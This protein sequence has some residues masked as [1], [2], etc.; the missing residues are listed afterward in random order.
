[1]TPDERHGEAQLQTQSPDLE[2]EQLAK[3]LDQ[4][5]AE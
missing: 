4:L 5:E 3:W 1:M 2:L